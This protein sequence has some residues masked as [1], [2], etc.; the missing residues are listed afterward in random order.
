MFAVLGPAV[1]T[2]V[3]PLIMTLGVVVLLAG[4]W[5][6]GLLNRYSAWVS[7]D[8]LGLGCVRDQSSVETDGWFKLPVARRPRL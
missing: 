1:T 8:R 3:L 5:C 4:S 7:I 6:L 2:A